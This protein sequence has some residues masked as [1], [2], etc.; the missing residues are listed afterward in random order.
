MLIT[1]IIIP[2]SLL[3]NTPLRELIQAHQEYWMG[4]RNHD[5]NDSNKSSDSS[6]VSNIPNLEVYIVDVWPSVDKYP[7]PFDLD[8]IRDRKNDLTYA[9]KTPYEEKVA[10]LISDY[11]NLA[12][13]LNNLANENNIDT[14]P[15]LIKQAKSKKRTGEN[16]F[17]RD[18]LKNQFDMTRVIR[19]ER[20]PDT[21]D[22]SNKWCD[23]SSDTIDTL[24]RQGI[25]D[26][27]RKLVDDIKKNFNK[28][29]ENKGKEVADQLNAFINEVNKSPTKTG[30]ES[31][32]I[33]SAQQIMMKLKG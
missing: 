26:T 15:I 28:D 12:N 2:V 1:I 32:V 20:S 13:D 19:I 3:S 4:P 29:H 25:I 14:G 23:F 27:L 9:D 31:E 5:K 7:L 33:N 17:Y 8:G 16:R 24:I 10:N 6:D 21:N 18:L 11:Y 22:I 30:Y